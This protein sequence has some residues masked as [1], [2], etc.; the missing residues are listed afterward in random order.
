MQYIQYITTAGQLCPCTDYYRG[1][2]DR[3][4]GFNSPQLKEIFLFYTAARSALGPPIL[5]A[6]AYYV[7]TPR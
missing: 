6:N 3:E 5:L 4:K 7:F 1:L 2:E